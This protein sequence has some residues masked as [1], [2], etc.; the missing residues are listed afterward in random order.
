MSCVYTVWTS[1]E[2][3][4]YLYWPRKYFAVLEAEINSLQ[5]LF[6]VLITSHLAV[7]VDLKIYWK[8]VGIIIKC[9]FEGVSNANS[10]EVVWFTKSH[11]PRNNISLSSLCSVTVFG[12][13]FY[14]SFRILLCTICHQFTGIFNIWAEWGLELETI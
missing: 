5:S 3:Y 1:W 10:V 2:M 13:H 8:A 14:L 4:Y 11:L 6:R 9:F 7:S 12:D